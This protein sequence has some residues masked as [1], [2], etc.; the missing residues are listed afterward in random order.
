M[1][2]GASS[3]KRIAEADGDGQVNTLRPEYAAGNAA[4]MPHLELSPEQLKA[5][6]P[7]LEV[8]EDLDFDDISTLEDDGLY[9]A[10]MV[11][12]QQI[13]QELATTGRT[14]RG[15]AAQTA[16]QPTTTNQPQPHDHNTTQPHDG[17]ATQKVR[18]A[19]LGPGC[20]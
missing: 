5:E 2:T 17:T 1:R 10:G 14:R 6:Y 3:K 8:P 16:T 11:V 19:E 12:V 15:G 7:S 18:A 20:P 9:Q 13:L 4:R